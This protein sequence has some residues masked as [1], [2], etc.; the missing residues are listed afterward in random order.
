MTIT[1]KTFEKNIYRVLNEKSKNKAARTFAEY[2][3][4]DFRA[5]NDSGYG[6]Y[7]SPQTY[8]G[9]SNKEVYLSKINTL[10][11]DLDV[12]KHGDGQVQGEIENKKNI[13]LAA[14]HA[15]A[16]PPSAIVDTRNGLQPY[17]YISVDDVTKDTVT[18]CRNVIISIS[19]WAVGYGSLGDKV[20]DI[21]HL[22]RVPGYFHNKSDPYM[23]R[24]LTETDITYSLSEL[25][26]AFP[27]HEPRKKSPPSST[28]AKVSDSLMER[29]N[30][31]DI[32]D[33]VVRAWEHKGHTAS[34]DK[35]NHLVV[36]GV[37]TASF[38]NREGGNFIATSSA[39]YPAKGNAV[40]YVAETLEIP[41]KEAYAWI[42]EMFKLRELDK[43]EKNSPE[44]LPLA[45]DTQANTLIKIVMEHPHTIL[46]TDQYRVPYIR[47]FVDNHLEILPCDS[48]RVLQ[49]L[50]RAYYE[51]KK[52]PA[53]P[54]SVKTA[55]DVIA[56]QASF[57]APQFTLSNRVAE[58]QGDIWY[59]LGD[60]SWNAVH[61]TKEGWT[62]TENSPTLFRRFS[63]TA[64][65]KYPI[66]GGSVKKVLDF[67]NITDDDTQLLFL[68]YLTACF[69]PGFPHPVLYI[70]G[71]QGSAKST[72]SKI[73]RRIID[74]SYIEVLS[75]TN[76]TEELVQQLAHHY[77]LFFDNVSH[78]P[79]VTADTLCRAV[80]GGGFA[81]RK[82]YSDDDD[83]IYYIR[84]N[85]GINGINI[86]STQP[87]LLER[88]LLLELKEMDS[89][90]RKEERRLMAEFEIALPAILGGA[91]D[92]VSRAMSM[93]PQVHVERPPR[94]ADFTLWGAAIADALGYGQE[95]FVTAYR[96]NIESQKE[97][98]LH[99]SIEAG[100]ILE[101][102]SVDSY[103]TGTPSELFD[104][105]HRCAEEHGINRRLLPQSPASMT[106]K[107]N[108]LLSTLKN[109]G[110]QMV[111]K[112][113]KERRITIEKIGDATDD[114]DDVF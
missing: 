109:A 71:P 47:L 56:A 52:A 80:T 11:A 105:I 46:F 7:Y 102:L 88:S 95:R 53:Q 108:T 21:V 40:T 84:T 8:A 58:H 107:L 65:Q 9:N 13:L 60:E 101:I 61:I 22:L 24:V 93:R 86:S 32:R 54:T 19:Q 45:Q 16:L 110:V 67:V 17:W 49:W 104:R 3:E 69:I 68:V 6:V 98:A 4:G 25:E 91:F 82:L 51:Q 63:H 41:R 20:D 10:F 76:R 79:Q 66:V 83:V 73:V 50:T 28:R 18:R 78:I 100:L 89:S 15:L 14:L 57:S 99:G 92:T 23:V 59:D 113:G 33:V 12:A 27:Y 43:I 30:S 26:E 103:W 87:D 37:L 94:M 106:R 114:S 62:C 44:Q 38:A 77:F 112:K 111:E 2:S 81:K 64:P 75:L 70:H 35:D 72:L 5:F 29:V 96:N 42:V 90:V 31:L 36:D 48:K 55:L 97:E 74:P 1:M 34:F 39:E 85:I